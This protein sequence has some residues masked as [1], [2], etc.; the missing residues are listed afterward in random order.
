MTCTNW[1]FSDR[2]ACTSVAT[3]AESLQGHAP[4][5][6][7]MAS[8]LRMQGMRDD[9]WWI[10]DRASAQLRQ[11]QCSGPVVCQAI[12]LDESPAGCL[13]SGAFYGNRGA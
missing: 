11:G 10:A 9:R 1:G 8:R 13:D 4:A 3:L 2:R 7:A 12:P 5:P 6:V